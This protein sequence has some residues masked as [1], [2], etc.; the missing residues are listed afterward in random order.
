MTENMQP[1][2]GNLSSPNTH[3]FIF[4][5]R[6]TLHVMWVDHEVFE[7]VGV[8]EN[9]E[10]F[11]GLIPH[12]RFILSCTPCQAIE[13]GLRLMEQAQGALHNDV[14]YHTEIEDPPPFETGTRARIWAAFHGNVPLPSTHDIPTGKMWDDI[15]DALKDFDTDDTHSDQ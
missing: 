3:T 5:A 4:A 9:D 2:Y 13:F 12:A 7:T 11:L 10:Q 6:G 15:K 8:P 1:G 14:P